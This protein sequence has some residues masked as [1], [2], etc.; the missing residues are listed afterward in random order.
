MLVCINVQVLF[1][2]DIFE[3][4]GIHLKDFKIITRK[5]ETKKIIKI[6]HKLSEKKFQ[7]EKQEK[8]YINLLEIIKI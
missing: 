7:L 4:I 1:Y 8:V 2:K 3:K 6:I 5:E